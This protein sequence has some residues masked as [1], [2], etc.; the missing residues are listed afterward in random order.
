MTDHT[1][2]TKAHTNHSDLPI[3]AKKEPSVAASSTSMKW[4]HSATVHTAELT[5]TICQKLVS[6]DGEKNNALFS[7]YGILF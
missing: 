2:L 3:T 1:T 6:I 4:V 7:R 5:M